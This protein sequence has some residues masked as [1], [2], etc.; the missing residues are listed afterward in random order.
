M[1]LE[2]IRKFSLRVFFTAAVFT[3]SLGIVY[4][5]D[6]E[7]WTGHIEFSAKPGS[8]RSLAKGDLFLPL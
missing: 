4:A 6:Q 2:L 8:D 3:Q 7:K 1:Q 5:Q